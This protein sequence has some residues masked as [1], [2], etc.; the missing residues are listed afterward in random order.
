MTDKEFSKNNEKVNV[1]KI[2]K[3][4]INILYCYNYNRANSSDLKKKS[5]STIFET[6]T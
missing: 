6:D 2:I 1:R 4:N 3:K 5:L